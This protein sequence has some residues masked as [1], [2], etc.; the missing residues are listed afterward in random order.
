[1]DVHCFCRWLK[2]NAFY[3]K[4]VI[5]KTLFNKTNRKNVNKFIRESN[6]SILTLIESVFNL[7]EPIRN[8]MESKVKKI[9]RMYVN[10]EKIVSYS[11]QKGLVLLFPGKTSDKKIRISFKNDTATL[12][13]RKE[14]E[15][16][17]AVLYRCDVYCKTVMFDSLIGDLQQ[18]YYELIAEKGVIRGTIKMMIELKFVLDLLS[19]LIDFMKDLFF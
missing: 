3:N 15:V 12:L 4:C 8:I 13:Y 11:N 6:V 5:C 16:G 1:M 18:K 9:E 14:N 17:P 7:D 10:T 19:E 2:K